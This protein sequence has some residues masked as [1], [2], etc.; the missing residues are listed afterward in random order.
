MVNIRI[1]IFTRQTVSRDSIPDHTAQFIQAFHNGDLVSHQLQVVSCSQAAG[2]AAHNGY[3]FARIR[4][5]FRSRNLSDM[6][7]CIAF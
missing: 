5:A 2:T 4:Q 7:C 1:Q 6:F 3:F